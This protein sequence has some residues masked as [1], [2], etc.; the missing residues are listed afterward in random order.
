MEAVHEL[1]SDDKLIVVTDLHGNLNDFRRYLEIW[2]REGG[3]ILFTGD[4]IH[5]LNGAGFDGSIEILETAMEFNTSPRFLILLGNHEWSHIINKCV[6]KTQ[7]NQSEEF[8]EALRVRFGDEWMERLN[9]YVEFFR[10][11]P[12]ALTTGNGVFISHAGPPFNVNSL[13]DI[14]DAAGDGHD[15]SILRGLLWNRPRKDYLTEDVE[16]FLKN[17]GCKAMIVGHTPVNGIEIFGER[18]L[19]MSSSFGLGKKAYMVLDSHKEIKDAW[20][21]MKYVRYLD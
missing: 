17:I 15:G 8:I 2:D 7:V 5:S 6:G 4:L 20:D 3:S 9:R 21:L 16:D 18:Q 13:Q 14:K 1:D 11:L 19:V 10:K 12:I